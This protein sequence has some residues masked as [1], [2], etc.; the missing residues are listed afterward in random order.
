MIHEP[1]DPN[2]TLLVV[3]STHEQTDDELTDKEVK[4]MEADDK[5]IQTI[6]MG[7]PKDIYAAIGSCD[8]AQ[9]VWLRVE[10]MMKSSNIGTQEKKAKL[11][12]ECEKFNSTEGES[13]ESYYHRFA[14][15]M[16]DFSINIHF[17]EKIA[18]NLKIINNLQSEWK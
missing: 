15:L 5:A 17:P 12:N 11:F 7:L 1:G 2:G 3:E 8:T 16:N 9:E 6:L 13:I 14:K 18:S 4:Q 10:Q